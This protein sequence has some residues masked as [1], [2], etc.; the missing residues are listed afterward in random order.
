MGA[1]QQVLVVDDGVRAVDHSLA[2]ELAELGYASVTASLEAA[3]DVLA[4]IARP[5]AVLFQSSDRRDP[6]YRR[7]AAQLRMQ[8]RDRGIPIIDIEASR[9]RR[10][11]GPVDLQTRIGAYVLQEPER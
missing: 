1:L 5:A 7:L 10:S 3:D 6:T 9:S 8:M 4:V 11:G 2:G